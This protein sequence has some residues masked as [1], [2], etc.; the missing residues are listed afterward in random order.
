MPPPKLTAEQKA[1]KKLLSALT[2]QHNTLLSAWQFKQIEHTWEA[3]YSKLG[4]PEDKWPQLRGGLDYK[5]LIEYTKQREKDFLASQLTSEVRKDERSLL[6]E[7]P[8]NNENT[9]NHNHQMGEEQRNRQLNNQRCEIV[10]TTLQTRE[11]TTEI[12]TQ[13]V[14]EVVKNTDEFTSKNN[15]GWVESTNANPKL[16]LFWFQK[17]ACAEGWDKLITNDKPAILLLS[18]TGTGKT[19]MLGALI[20][21]MMD[22]D[23]HTGTT[24]SHIPYVYVTKASIVIK[25]ERA[26]NS[27]FCITVEDTEVINIELLRS[28][29]GAYWIK[30]ETKVIGG[31]EVEIFVWK[32][33]IKPYFIGWDECQTLK[34]K[35][36]QQHQIACA[37]TSAKGF[38]TKQAFVSATPF[39]KVGEAKCFAIA[40][41]KDITY[42][43][44][45][46]SIFPE[47]ARLTEETW[48]TYAKIICGDGDPNEYN[49]A[50]CKR[51]MDDLEDYV[52][53]VK[54]VRPQFEAQNRVEQIDF[55]SQEAREYYTKAWDRYLDK[56]AKLEALGEA[57]INTGMQIL[58]QF[59]KFRMAA[60]YIRHDI[61]VERMI[62]IVFKGKAA[63]C[64]VSF[65]PTLI[66]MVMLFEKK[67]ITR[68]K[69]SIIWGGGQT[70]LTE[71]EKQ[72]KAIMK[73]PQAQ[74]DA[75]GVTRE[76]LLEDLSLEDVEDKEL[77]DVPE[78]MRLGMQSIEE[79]QREIDKFQ[80]GKTL[81]CIYTLKA[82]GVGLSL[83]HTDE[84]LP[85]EKQ[86]RRKESGYV[87]EEDIPKIPTRE[88]ETIVAP[89]WSPIEMVQGV[90]RVPR[91]TSLS[92][93][94]QTLLYYKGTIE[95]RVADI[96]SRGLRCLNAIVKHR[97]PW[98]DFASD[99]NKYQKYVDSLPDQVEDSHGL[100][101]E[102]ETENEEGE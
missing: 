27:Q 100:V 61:L 67:G 75:Q 37:L 102:S 32:P 84:H 73:I 31:E 2:Y 45:K 4:I 56:K 62:E 14:Q 88:R 48:N 77:I 1:Q 12:N 82:G 70:Q 28:Q 44:G 11:K 38:T 10:Q 16:R 72:R 22:E 41:R 101:D 47:G 42:I 87:Y 55:Q 86:C 24:M 3:I 97:E 60:E 29:A 81:F 43:L 21:R 83:H 80:T 39:T 68:D 79:R 49:E 92:E 99:N 93:T 30:R 50:A 65:K 5:Q 6:V 94:V 19:W 78:H 36:S 96:A 74:L 15:Y 33:V 25:T 91:L 53:R 58:V 71:K 69:I 54:G 98:I 18:G 34:N 23:L 59:L 13:K 46:R 66:A 26:L 35:G 20:R 40:T 64:A 8:I 63:V 89:T 90:G 51:L 85:F 7:Q 17:K 52:V 57:G 95:S 9:L 76:E